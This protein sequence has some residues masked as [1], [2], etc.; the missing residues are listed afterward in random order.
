MSNQAPEKVVSEQTG[1]QALDH[2]V[3]LIVDTQKQ[4]G[5]EP[6][7]S[8]AEA[9]AK[10]LVLE[11]FRRHEEAQ[12]RAPLVDKD[13]VDARGSTAKSGQ[14]KDRIGRGEVGDYQAVLRRPDWDGRQAQKKPADKEDR[15]VLSRC[16]L[17]GQ[18]PEWRDRLMKAAFDGECAAMMSGSPHDRQDWKRRQSIIGDFMMRVIE[19]SNAVFGDYRNPKAKAPTI[20]GRPIV[21]K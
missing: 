20:F 15:L 13:G 14:A 3:K 17:L 7:Q 12:R 21:V 5:V 2:V 4:L 6:S 11:Q 18:F 19:Q 10:P 1:R 16:N 9:F 8:K